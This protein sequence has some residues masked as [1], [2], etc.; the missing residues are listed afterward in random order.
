M[1]PIT[2]SIGSITYESSKHL[3]GILS[4]L[5]GRTCHHI[6][7]S[8]D[9]MD[10]IK[11][12]KMEQGEVVSYDVTALFTSVPVDK[13]LTVIQHRLENYTE[14]Q[15][16]TQMSVSQIVRL[17]KFCLETSYFVYGGIFYRQIH[18]AAMGSPVSPIVCN[19]YMEEVES[20]ALSTA[21]HPPAWWYRYVDDT[22][23]KLQSTHVD[24]FTDHLN[25]VDAD[26]KFTHEKEE[27]GKLPFLDT[28]SEKREDG[29]IKLKVYRKPTHTNQYLNFNSNHPLHQKLGVIRTLL[30]RVDSIITDEDDKEKE[31]KQVSEALMRC[32][33]PAWAIERVKRDMTTPKEQTT[34]TDSDTKQTRSRGTVVVPY[35]K[36]LSETLARV[37]KGYGVQVCIKPT[38]TLRANLVAP[39]DKLKKEDVCGPVYYIPCTDTNCSEFYIGETERS[40]RTRFM[41]HKRPSSVSSSEVAEHIYIESPGHQVDVSEVKILD[42]DHRYFERGVKEAAYI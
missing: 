40:L 34:N 33:Y 27:N 23:C 35:I 19:L 37:L 20:R 13:A 32:G 31:R 21:P 22:H 10:K 2:S 17:L 26:I 18:G 5:V 14:L 36:D 30:H 25:S 6:N 42:R 28:E 8:K 1:R 9:F 29:S 11:N 15:N 3:A 39:K 4:P 41:E 7:N 12:E 38:Q 24:E 16:H